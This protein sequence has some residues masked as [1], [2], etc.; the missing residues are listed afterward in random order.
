MHGT[1]DSA[2]FCFMLVNQAGVCLTSWASISG[3]ESISL[4]CIVFGLFYASPKFLDIDTSMTVDLFSGNITKIKIEDQEFNVIKHIYSSLILFG[5]GTHIFLVQHKDGKYHIL[6]DAW[7]LADHRISEINILSSISN[8]LKNDSS[9]D[10]HK[11]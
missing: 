1:H 6:K 3:Y 8:T 9:T 5:H 7:L 2:E 4:I 11:Y 10:A